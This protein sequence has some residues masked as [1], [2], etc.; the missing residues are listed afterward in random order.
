[1]RPEGFAGAVS[2]SQPPPARPA[3][4]PSDAPGALLG[5]FP[6]RGWATTDDLH[7]R[8]NHAAKDGA[9]L[10]DIYLWLVALGQRG[11]VVCAVPY[12]QHRAQDVALLRWQ[13]AFV[14]G[15]SCTE[16]DDAC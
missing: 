16:P 7:A 2:I 8:Y 11:M 5:L 1:M 14:H 3:H 6:A 15:R 4:E 9:D 13:R 10:A 12:G